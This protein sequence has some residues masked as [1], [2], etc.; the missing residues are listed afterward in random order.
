MYVCCRWQWVRWSFSD[1][2]VPP[3]FALT[4]SYLPLPQHVCISRAPAVVP[5]D[6]WFSAVCPPIAGIPL[7]P[8]LGI[9]GPLKPRVCTVARR[10][11]FTPFQPPFPAGER[12]YRVHR[13]QVQNVPRWS[14]KH[15]YATVYFLA[16]TGVPRACR[17]LLSLCAKTPIFYMF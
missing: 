17:P 11:F 2:I 3:A 1:D 7:N 9:L 14:N 4:F 15:R 13:R 8:L 10:L 5:E 16:Q 6:R 12:Q